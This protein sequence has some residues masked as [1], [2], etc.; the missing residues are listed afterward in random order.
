MIPL[1]SN[2]NRLPPTSP[3]QLPIFLL[4]LLLSLLRTVQDSGFSWNSIVVVGFE[5]TCNLD[6]PP[7]ISR[8]S[9]NCAH[10]FQ[11]LAVPS[12][13]TP[14]RCGYGRQPSLFVLV[15]ALVSNMTQAVAWLLR[16]FHRMPLSRAYENPRHWRLDQELVDKM[17]RHRQTHEWHA[18]YQTAYKNQT[19]VH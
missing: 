17:L 19:R 14:D 6:T 8:P 7:S 16:D 2:C 12:K 11:L 9:G 10:L 15:Y 13:A 5:K 18:N 1:K 4:E 3:R